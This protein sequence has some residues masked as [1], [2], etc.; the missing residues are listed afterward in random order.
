[1]KRTL[2]S[3][4]I[5]TIL[6]PTD[7]SLGSLSGVIKAAELAH[8]FQA[9]LILMTAVPK[10]RA[11]A[12]QHGRYL[13]QTAGTVRMQLASWFARQVPAAMRQGLSVRFLAV[14]GTPVDMILQVTN[15]EGV[16]LIVMAIRG[17]SGLRR[18]LYGSVAEGVARVS[19]SPVLT[20][21]T[22]GTPART[23]AVA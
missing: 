18:L 23:V 11:T 10:P 15:T 17:R 19:P 3:A 16:D 5:K 1:M 8:G 4:A 13:D 2:R 20:I 7:L 9:N 12:E 21:R 22:D 14:I 6:A